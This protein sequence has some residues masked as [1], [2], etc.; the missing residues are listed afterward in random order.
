MHLPIVS[1]QGYGIR[2][3]PSYLD[4]LEE[5]NEKLD[6]ISRGEDLFDLNVNDIADASR[7]WTATVIRGVENW[8][9]YPANL[10]FS[11]RDLEN[12]SQVSSEPQSRSCLSGFSLFMRHVALWEMERR[13]EVM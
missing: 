6:E 4:S 1:P 3:L 12:E 11:H 13:K 8:K 9:S 5:S 10:E 7:R 2:I